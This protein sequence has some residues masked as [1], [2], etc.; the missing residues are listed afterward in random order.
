MADMVTVSVAAP[1]S[2]LLTICWLNVRD[3][4]RDILAGRVTSV[5]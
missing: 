3:E 2:L 1:A 5:R 4:R